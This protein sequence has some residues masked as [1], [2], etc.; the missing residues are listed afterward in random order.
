MISLYNSDRPAATV[1]AGEYRLPSAEE[2]RAAVWIDLS[3]PLEEETALVENALGVELPGSDDMSEIEASSRVYREDGADFMT[4]LLVVGMD[5]NDPAAVP[6]SFILTAGGQLVTVRYCDP[7]SFR[8]A[9]TH[10]MRQPLGTT[11]F[12]VLLKLL[13]LIVDRTADILEYMGAEI[14]RTSR[15]IFGRNDTDERRMSPADLQDILRVI[16]QIQFTVNKAHDS[17]QTL[18]RIATFLSTPTDNG[19]GTS[20]GRGDKMLR[21]SLKSIVRDIASLTENSNYQMQNVYFLLDAAVGR[22]SIE[23]NVIVKILSIASVVL[24]PPTLIASM[25]GMNFAHMPELESEIGYPL[26]L[27]LM[28]ASA[29]LPYLYFRRKGWL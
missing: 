14:D 17:L 13:D 20:S 4:A 6:V 28:V 8:T 19:N 22:I 5:R 15:T 18:T 12:A 24:M 9:A 3:S 16:G 2:L 1:A 23:Q 21:D 25:Y 7:N 26:I 29:I 27:T 10:A 11:G